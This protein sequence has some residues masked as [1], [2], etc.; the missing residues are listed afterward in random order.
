M[1]RTNAAAIAFS[2]IGMGWLPGMPT[3]ILWGSERDVKKQTSFRNRRHTRLRNQFLVD[4]Y[5]LSDDTVER[6]RA[7]LHRG[8]VA[9]YGFTSM[10]EFAARRILEKKIHLPRDAVRT[11][12]N[13]AGIL[14]PKQERI[15]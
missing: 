8:P 11:A 9:V 10:L 7:H 15:L 4:G 3:I 2:A 13:G 5:N 14:F 12:P 1:V 6:M